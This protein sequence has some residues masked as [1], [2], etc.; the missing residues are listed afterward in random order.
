MTLENG[1]S[2]PTPEEV[3]VY[4]VCFCAQVGGH[5]CCLLVRP[6]RW[7]SMLA[8]YAQTEI[9]VY[10]VY[11][12]TRGGVCLGC[13]LVCLRRC[14]VLVV[15]LCATEMDISVLLRKFSSF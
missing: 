14:L 9:D 15:C 7:M 2:V 10:V 6:R 1:P 13:L 4:V 11:L 3:D 12:C 5:L 8:A